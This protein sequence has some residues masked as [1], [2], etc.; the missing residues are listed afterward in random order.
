ME[1][2]AN[3]THMLLLDLSVMIGS[4]LGGLLVDKTGYTICFIV[5]AVILVAG[6]IFY[7]ALQPI[8]KKTIAQA[9]QLEAE[10]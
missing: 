9:A 7:L 6:A 3:S 10:A 5:T 1:G 2:L 4:A 8:I